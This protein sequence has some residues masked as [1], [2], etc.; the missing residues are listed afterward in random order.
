MEEENETRYPLVLLDLPL[1]LGPPL[2]YELL[3]KTDPV[4]R[5]QVAY[6]DREASKNN[7]YALII[8]SDFGIYNKL[9]AKGKIKIQFD[10]DEFDL[11]VEQQID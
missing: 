4:I 10:G 6:S 1:D 9:V 2:L 3:N 7:G 11:R 8:L 5:V